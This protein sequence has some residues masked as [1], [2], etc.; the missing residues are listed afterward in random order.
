L[1]SNKDLT[2]KILGFCR[3]IAGSN[4]IMGVCICGFTALE[5]SSKKV[6]VEVLV[7]IR[8]FQPRIMVYVKPLNRYNLIVS[9]VDQWVFEKDVERAFIGEVVAEKIAFYYQPIMGEEYFEEHEIKVKKR[10]ICELLETLI[11]EFPE[12]SREFLIEPKYFLYE[13]MM[14][15][16]KLFPPLTYSF[17]NML[18]KG[19]TEAI[20][21]GYKRALE[22]LE[23]EEI[24]E[25]SGEYVQISEKLIEKTRRKKIRIPAFFK[26]FQKAFFA[27]TLGILPK[28]ANVFL[29]YRE[30][31]L[32][33]DWD[34]NEEELVFRLENPRK[35]IYVHTSL[36]MLPLSDRTGIEDFVKKIVSNKTGLHMEIKEIGGILNDVYLITLKEDGQERKIVV[37]RFMDWQSFKWFSLALWTLGTQSFAVHGRSRLEKEY[38]L[39]KFLQS[40]RIS[41]PR[42][43]HVS[44]KERLI[45][46]EYVEGEKVTEVVRRIFKAKRKSEVARELEI[47]RKIGRKM[48]HIHELGVSLGDTKPENILISNGE[49]LFLD[50]EQAS[51]NGNQPWDIAE[52]L[53]YAGH[54]ASLTTNI[55]TVTWLT[56]AFIE[57]YL[58][59]GGELQNVEKAASPLYTKVFSI[60]TLPHVIFKISSLCKK[61][62]KQEGK[63]RGES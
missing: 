20:M 19:K 43:L 7:V 39:N 40:K 31:L 36:G 15:R 52:F 37:K 41:V 12:L 9:A 49:V 34:K 30:K 45:F 57:G 62:A 50:L 8:D 63:S 53:Y 16:A 56:Q 22:E 35:H 46:R 4:P 29:Q 1:Q 5:A 42:I 26:N 11:L 32:K 3:Q 27:Y 2:K 48:A 55:R 61:L 13:T 33:P 54:C 6:D 28:T 58:E 23:E 47:I 60:F 44:L 10:I 24:I 25:F 14:R 21:R 51:R 38:A 17:L 59:A 18:Q